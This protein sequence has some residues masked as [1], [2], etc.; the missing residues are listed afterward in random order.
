MGTTDIDDILNQAK[1]LSAELDSMPPDDPGRLRIEKRQMR[2]REKALE[3][4]LERRHPV[5]IDNEIAML[6]ARL[7]KISEML[8]SKGYNE[9]HLG[10]TIQDPGAYSSTINY[11]IA[12]EHAEE[13][14]QIDARLNELRA[15]QADEERDPQS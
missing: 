13:V 3:L 9:K 4:S 11:M 8:I 14:R 6:E 12:A 15:V 5:S 7:E 2:L 1:A 10:T